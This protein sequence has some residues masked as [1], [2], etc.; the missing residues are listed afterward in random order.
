MCW[1][2]AHRG[3]AL[4]PKPPCR[5]GQDF[6]FW[7]L[8][9]SGRIAFASGSIA[10]IFRLHG[11]LARIDFV[12]FASSRRFCL[13][14]AARRRETIENRAAV[15]G[16]VRATGCSRLQQ[17]AQRSEVRR[18]FAETAHVEGV[19]RLADR[20]Q[21]SSSGSKSFTTGSGSTAPW[22]T[23]HLWTSKL[24]STKKPTSRCTHPSPV[25]QIGA[26]P[27][28]RNC[29]R[30]GCTSSNC[31]T[32][33]DCSAT[34]SPFM[35]RP[36]KPPISVRNQSADRNPPRGRAREP[37]SRNHRL[38]CQTPQAGEMSNFVQPSA[39]LTRP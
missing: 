36:S 18:D 2:P 39:E 23:S 13:A 3:F 24:N 25:H 11:P 28:W 27:R 1:L 33:T 10:V 16:S 35:S 8:R 20:V 15:K 21:P 22:V 19:A 4:C 32:R 34:I 37:H 9:G 38:L 26:R 31:N 5:Y 6:A 7:T 30:P 12:A 29:P 17:F 14:T